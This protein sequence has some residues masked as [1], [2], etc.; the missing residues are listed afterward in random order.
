M[1]D[2]TGEKVTKA[3]SDYV[4][5]ISGNADQVSMGN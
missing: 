3:M 5:A 2:G 4:S 1:T